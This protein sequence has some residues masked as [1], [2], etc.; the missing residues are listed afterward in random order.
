MFQRLDRRPTAPIVLHAETTGDSAFP[1]V[2]GFLLS[3]AAEGTTMIDGY[4]LANGG[5]P[6]FFSDLAFGIYGRVLFLVHAP[7]DEPKH[8]TWQPFLEV[9]K[10]HAKAHGAIGAWLVYGERAG[11]SAAQRKQCSEL[12]EDHKISIAVLTRSILARRMIT[13]IS[14]L[15][16]E[17]RIKPFDTMDLPGAFTYLGVPGALVPAM[18]GSFLRVVQSLGVGREYVEERARSA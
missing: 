10:E 8:E 14:W 9:A 4:D 13:A 6:K 1:D 7:V 2:A 3:K 17:K 18:R 5:E 11:L 12:M 16:R 15:T